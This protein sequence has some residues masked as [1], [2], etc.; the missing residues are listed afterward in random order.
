MNIRLWAPGCSLQEKITDCYIITMLL[1][2]PL[3]PGFS[4]YR[5]IT[6]S[7][8]LFFVIAACLWLAALAVSLFRCGGVRPRFSAAGYAAL[9]YLLVCILSWLCSPYRA[10]ALLGAGRYDGLLTDALYVLIFLGVSAFSHPK[11]L[12]ARAF[13]L[14]VTLCL[15]VALLQ[16]GGADLLHL[17]PDGVD[18]YDSGIVYSGAFLGTVGNTNVLDAVLCLSLPLFAALFL[19]GKGPFW[20]VPLLPGIPVLIHAGG[21]GAYLALAVT[22]LTALPLLMT[23]LRRVRTLLRLAAYAVLISAASLLWQPDRGTGLHVVFSAAAGWLFV[24]ALVLYAASLLPL[25]DRKGCSA[26]TLRR[27]FALLSLLL[28]LAALIFVLLSPAE[29]GTVYELRELLHGH[30]EDGFGSSRIRIWRRCLALTAERPLLGGGPGTVSLRLDIL[31]S[32]FVPETGKTLQSYADNAHNIYLAALADTGIPGLAALLAL[33]FFSARSAL[34]HA[35]EPLSNAFAVGT[36]CCAV[37]EFFGLGLCLSAPLLWL[38]LGLLCS[39]AT[40][41]EHLTEDTL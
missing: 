32:R 17:F 30:A 29:S 22:A 16:L 5:S 39:G 33:F 20:L 27:C 36:L 2:F 14:S 7:K 23:E 31:F 11:L 18:F 1:I 38:C 10:E 26:R 41:S 19:C 28:L 24:A 9:A 13:A 15:L 37:H 34:L 21:D 35:G 40:K 3:F 12:Y 25:F 6:L 8:F 4:G